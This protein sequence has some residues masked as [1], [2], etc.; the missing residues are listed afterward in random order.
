[1]REIITGAIAIALSFCALA[2][3]LL[4]LKASP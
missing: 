2:L 4:A 3:T 1:M